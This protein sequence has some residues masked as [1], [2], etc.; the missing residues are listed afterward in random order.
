MK[1]FS[2]SW[3][4]SEK[5]R[6]QRKY[7][8]N[9]PNH[10]KRDMISSHL[11]EGLRKIHGRRSISPRKGDTIKI[12]RGSF[13]KRS[14]KISGVDVKKGKIF[15]DGMQ[16]TKKDGSKISVPFH[17]SNLMITELNMDDKKRLKT[18]NKKQE[19]KSEKK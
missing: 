4:S 5:P 12:M 1:K 13:K 10:V 16:K 17:P 9:A 2:T 3:I 18:K 14:G 15:V 7:R 11:S 6:K 8:A 19:I